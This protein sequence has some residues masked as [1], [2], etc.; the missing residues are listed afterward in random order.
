M[1]RRAPGAS[2][3]HHRGKRPHR[4]AGSLSC[5]VSRLCEEVERFRGRPL[6]DPYPYVWLD[7]D[8][9]N[10]LNPSTHLGA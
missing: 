7:A 10:R 5:Q 4:K 9:F 8:F 3:A 2:A 6:E 1:R